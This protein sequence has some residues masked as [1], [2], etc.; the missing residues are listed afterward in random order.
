MPEQDTNLLPLFY[1]YKYKEWIFDKLMQQL[2]FKIYPPCK[3]WG[4]RQEMTP[5]EKVSSEI[6]KKFTLFKGVLIKS[7]A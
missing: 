3:N 4:C 2:V 5:F 1:R 6:N 7:E